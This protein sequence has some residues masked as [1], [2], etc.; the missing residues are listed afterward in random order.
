MRFR[1]KSYAPGVRMKQG[2]ITIQHGDVV[3][4]KSGPDDIEILPKLDGF[5]F[6]QLF[7]YLLFAMPDTL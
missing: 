2:E 4:V 7:L 5:G 3:G 1:R 6:R